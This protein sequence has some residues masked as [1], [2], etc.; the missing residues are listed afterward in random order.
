MR[1]AAPSLCIVPGYRSG[2]R[3][4]IRPIRSQRETGVVSVVAVPFDPL[5]SAEHILRQDDNRAAKIRLIVDIAREMWGYRPAA[6][7]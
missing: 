7:G 3:D 5:F 1:R 2:F 6:V 4:R